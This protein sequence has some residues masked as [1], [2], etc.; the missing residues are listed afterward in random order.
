MFNGLPSD[1][2]NVSGYNETNAER[3][4]VR[5]GAAVWNADG[6]EMQKA[7]AQNAMA[8]KEDAYNEE[9]AERGMI[10]GGEAVWAADGRQSDDK[11][12]G[13]ILFKRL[14]L[15]NEFLVKGQGTNVPF[16]AFLKRKGLHEG[17]FLAELPKDLQFVGISNET[18]GSKRLLAYGVAMN[19]EYETQFLQHIVNSAPAELS[20]DGGACGCGSASADGDGAAKVKCNLRY[21]P[22]RTGKR[23]D[24]YNACL[25][26]EAVKIVEKRDEKKAAGIGALGN[27]AGVYNKTN[28]VLVMARNSFLSILS[29]NLANT[30]KAF[31]IVKDK[32]GDH[33]NKIVKKW[34]IFGGDLNALKNAISNGRG[35]EPAFKKLLEKFHK[36]DGEWDSAEGGGVGKLV[37]GAAGAMGTIT[38]V[39]LA[40]PEPTAAT[41]A[42]AAWT[43]TASGTMAT[44]VPI[45]NSFAKQNGATDAD[46]T[47]AAGGSTGD[48]ALDAA[49]T[50]VDYEKNT[51]PIGQGFMDKYKFYVVG[52]LVLAMGLTAL[53]LTAKNPRGALA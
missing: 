38:G 39:L 7:N 32:K 20:C 21:P 13:K 12:R 47:P 48:P 43:G 24:A 6:R 14:N 16:G 26:T 42:A 28:P 51:P 37:A 4:M 22:P 11:R 40:I 3:G 33:W 2:H 53:I 10:Q 9:N 1:L 27:I 46:I 29:I 35:K 41:K 44:M 19:K 50:S 30:A 45:L 23:K 5:G 8:A 34:V 36:A 17:M 15:I 52:G 18:P 31:G 49:L 25:K